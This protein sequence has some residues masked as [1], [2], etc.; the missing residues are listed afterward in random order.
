MQLQWTFDDDDDDNDNER[1]EPQGMLKKQWQTFFI[2]IFRCIL[3]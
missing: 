3:F 1:L 2:H